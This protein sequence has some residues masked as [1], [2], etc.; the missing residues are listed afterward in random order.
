MNEEMCDIAATSKQ[1]SSPEVKR[2]SLRNLVKKISPPHKGNSVKLKQNN[3]VR[4]NSYTEDARQGAAVLY[5]RQNSSK[6]CENINGNAE[7]RT[8]G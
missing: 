5:E 6:R 2:S 4:Q 1:N 7:D 3:S 8:E